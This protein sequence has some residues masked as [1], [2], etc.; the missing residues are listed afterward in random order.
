MHHEGLTDVAYFV[1][2]IERRRAGNSNGRS[3][4]S[5]AFAT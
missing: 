2:V 1:V 4:W 5:D 3:K